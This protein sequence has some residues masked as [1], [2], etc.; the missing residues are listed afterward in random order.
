MEN[1]NVVMNIGGK[2]FD[3]TLDELRNGITFDFYPLKTNPVPDVI[4]PTGYV[5]QYSEIYPNIIR[6]YIPG[7]EEVKV[8]FSSLIGGLRKYCKFVLHTPTDNEF[9]FIIT[10]PVGVEVS[11]VTQTVIKYFQSFGIALY[12]VSSRNTRV[13]LNDIDNA[14]SETIR[15]DAESLKILDDYIRNNSREFFN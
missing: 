12:D 11:N 5:G 13:S 10:I 2:S 4:K 14:Y 9:T 3:I 7:A 1:I 6:V 8:D 15:A